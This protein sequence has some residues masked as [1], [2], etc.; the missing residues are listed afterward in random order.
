MHLR[1]REEPKG[2][3][4]RTDPV[5]DYQRDA[6]VGRQALPEV[7]P[8]E[9]GRLVGVEAVHARDL[10][11][12]RV[13]R[14][15]QRPQARGQRQRLVER[16]GVVRDQY[17]DVPGLEPRRSRDDVGLAGPLV[18]KPHDRERGVAE[19]DARRGVLQQGDPRRGHPV[20]RDVDALPLVVIAQ[21]GVDAPLR[22]EVRRLRV[23]RRGPVVPTAHV[24]AAKKHDV[25]LESVDPLDESRH[26]S[27]RRT[28]ARRGCRRGRRGW[29]RRGRTEARGCAACRAVRRV[30]G[31]L[32]LRATTI[33]ATVARTAAAAEESWGDGGHLG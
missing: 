7:A 18:G 9:A 15:R 5:R 1:P 31:P 17:C 28:T 16:V 24:V 14:E 4:D 19:P 32:G 29:P 26:A 30:R 22:R 25:S 13:P 10:A 6:A 27:R 21:H 33:R 2:Q 12:V 8:P 11:S 23:E 3:R 20:A